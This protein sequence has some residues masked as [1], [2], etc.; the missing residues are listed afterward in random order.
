[1]KK[2]H[3]SAAPI[4]PLQWLVA[5]LLICGAV[6]VALLLGDPIGDRAYGNV[7]ILIVSFIAFVC[8]LTWFSVCSGSPKLFRRLLP[9]AVVGAVAVAAMTLRIERLSGTL[10][11]KFAPR[12]T[13]PHDMLLAEPDRSDTTVNLEITST[14]DFPQ[15]LSKK[16]DQQV[17]GVRLARDWTTTA[18][19]VVWRRKIGA[20][21]SGFVAVN[22]FALTMEQRGESE[23]TTCYQV[24]TGNILWWHAD[25]VRFYEPLGGVGPRSTPTI[26]EGRVYAVG[27]TGILNCLRGSDGQVVWQRNILQDVGTTLEQDQ[28]LISWGRSGSP[29]VVDDKVVVPG[30]GPKGGPCVS[31]LAYDKRTGDIVWRG[32]E[33]QISYS[34]PQLTNLD[35]V[36]QILIVNE[37]TASAHDVATGETL[38][39]TEW[40]GCSANNASV[41]QAV[42]LPD[43]RVFLSKGYFE[44]CKVVRVAGG[45]DENWS[46]T[47]GWHEHQLL[48]TKLTNVCVR[49]HFAYGLSDGILECVDLTDGRRQWKRGRFGHGQILLVDDLLLVQSEKGNIAIVDAIPERFM[50]LG[51]MEVLSGQSWNHLCLYNN[52]LLMRSD[53]E[54]AC[55]ALPLAAEA[56]R[57]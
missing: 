7:A 36:P 49:D 57:L 10:V 34:S 52:L 8:A 5:V 46:V 25:Q 42:P 50:M 51:E 13:K 35:G 15:F 39:E 47:E 2:S 11:P 37:A 44:G 43:N 20:G 14:D 32:G 28:D 24:K 16:R 6:V 9:I 33:Q 56:A 19:R 27:A 4:K 40:N 53:E 12:W 48:K 21:W 1:M 38:W 3:S 29:L 18:P 22:G 31:L 55:L 17:R 45:T 41:S 30:G 23:L 54:A 26:H